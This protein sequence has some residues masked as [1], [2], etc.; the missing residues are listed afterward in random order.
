MR[1]SDPS[2]SRL[3]VARSRRCVPFHEAGPHPST[4][5]HGRCGRRVMPDGKV[6]VGFIGA[7]WW[8]TANHMPLLAAREDVELTAVCRLGR[9][10]LEQ[11]RQRFGFRHAYEDYRAMLAEVEL[12]AVVVVSPHTL[13]FEHARAALEHNLH[14]LCEKPMTVRAEEARELVGLAEERNLHLL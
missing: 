6:R 4:H 2:P 1:L 10:E 11:V 12:D 8:A 3:P 7:G 9:A 5:E 14:V 13:H